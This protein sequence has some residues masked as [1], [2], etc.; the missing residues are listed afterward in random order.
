VLILEEIYNQLFHFK[1]FSALYTKYLVQKVCSSLQFFEKFVISETVIGL[2]D[3]STVRWGDSTSS[4][5]VFGD[6]ITLLFTILDC[7]HRLVRVLLKCLKITLFRGIDLLR[8][9]V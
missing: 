9:Q 2:L 5:N 3:L 8:H 7:M 6:G 4:V 1:F